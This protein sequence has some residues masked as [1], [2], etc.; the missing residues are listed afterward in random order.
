MATNKKVFV[1]CPFDQQY[2]PILKAILFTNICLGLEPLISETTNS[3]ESRFRNIRKFIQ[4]SRFS[5][6]DLSRLEPLN[7]DDLPRMNMPFELGL[8]FGAKY[9]NKTLANKKFLILE[10]ER[11]RYQK[12]ISDLSGHDVGQHNNKPVEAIK[13]IRNWLASH[14]RGRLPSYKIIWSA[15]QNFKFEYDQTLRS[16]NLD[17][18]VL[19]EIPFGE[20]IHEMKGWIKNELPDNSFDYPDFEEENNQL[21]REQQL[22]ML[23]AKVAQLLQRIESEAGSGKQGLLKTRKILQE[24]LNH[25]LVTNASLADGS[26]KFEVMKD[27][28]QIEQEIKVIETSLHKHSIT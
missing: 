17:P 7:K 22:E 1:N 4:N 24:K 23:I 8:D 21:V 15:Y 9:F 11:F 10:A 2:F 14:V 13:A 6:H 20:I 12:V 28:Q 27:I 5:I 19:G 16:E 26:K 18:D 3:G 25:L